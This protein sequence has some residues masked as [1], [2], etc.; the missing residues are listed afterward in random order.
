MKKIIFV[1]IFLTL[2]FPLFAQPVV[3]QRANL[4]ANN[5]NSIFQNTGIFN[6]NTALTNVPGC[7]WP[8]GSGNHLCFTT[9][10]TMAAMI[11]DSLAYTC[12][13]YRGEYSPGTVINGVYTTNSNFKIYSIKSGDNCLNNPDYANWGLMVP[14]GAPYKDINQNGTYECNI[15]IPGM[16]DASQTIFMCLTD[17]NAGQ[18]SA[19]EGFGGGITKPLFKSQLAITAWGYNYSTVNNAQF[20]RYVITNKNNVTWKKM[21]LSLFSDPDIGDSDDDM[22]GCSPELDLG[23]AYNSDN[24]DADY[25]LNPPAFGFTVLRSPFVLRN[26]IQDTLGM[27]SFMPLFRN[28]SGLPPCVTE[29][30]SS[31][32]VYSYMKGNKKDGTSWKLHNSNPLTPTKYVFNGDPETQTGWTQNKGIT[33]DCNGYNP[34][35]YDSLFGGDI[36][37][38]MNTGSDSLEI[39]PNQKIEYTI[40]QF[41]ERGSSNL[42]SVT[43]LKNRAASLRTFYNTVVGS[44][45][46]SHNSEIIA[47]DYMLYQNY[48]N[49]FNPETNIK[50]DVPKTSQVQ[51]EVFDMNG[52]LVAALVNQELIAGQ[53]EARFNAANLSSGV[54]VYRLRAG[55]VVYSNTM[56]LL[57]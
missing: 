31:G 6:Q 34:V 12:A 51:L 46:I 8:V 7:E 15:D 10:L 4:R 16:P 55:N 49:P 23:Y 44:I 28:M 9:G 39:Q 50:F 18:H 2:S 29:G 47:N 13:S 3:V 32:Q 5:I 42:N 38:I 53:Y 17:A 41:V 30:A 40:A 19:G 33:I 14:Y 48:P 56:L 24:D 25:G 26:G 37:M 1:F 36:K 43:L 54:Y 27:T 45:S 20:I 21:H 22:V 35:I 57:K 52:K 11:N